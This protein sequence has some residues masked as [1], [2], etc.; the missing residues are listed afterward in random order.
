MDRTD[1]EVGTPTARGSSRPVRYE[2]VRW[3]GVVSP[4]KF[5]SATR[6]VEAAGYLWPGQKQDPDRTGAGWDIQVVDP[7][8]S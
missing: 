5:E 8:L 3:D 7:N 4:M 2:L 1:L 6:A